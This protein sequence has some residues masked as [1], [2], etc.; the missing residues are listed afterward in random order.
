MRMRRTI[1]EPVMRRRRATLEPGIDFHRETAS[2]EPETTKSVSDDKAP[3][4]T[5]PREFETQTVVLIVRVE[6]VRLH[7]R[8]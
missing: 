1:T 5:Q 4:P 6:V 7:V 2:P 3:Y 8:S